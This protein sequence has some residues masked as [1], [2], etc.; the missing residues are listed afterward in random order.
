M[1]KDE[2]K[3]FSLVISPSEK[4][5]NHIS[6]DPMKLKAYTAHVMQEYA[7]N[8]RM[9][10]GQPLGEKDL[11]WVA[12]KHEERKHRGH[13]GAPSGQLKEGLQTHIHVMVSAHNKQQ[14]ITLNPLG[15]AARFNR[16]GFYAKSNVA[17]EQ[18][19]G[20]LQQDRTQ[21]RDAANSWA[22][23]Q[24]Q[25]QQTRRRTTQTAEEIADSIRRRAAVKDG[26]A[27]RPKRAYVNCRFYEPADE[28]RDR[29][30]FAQVDRA[31]KARSVDQQLEHNKVLEAARRLDYSKAFYGRLG[32]LEREAKQQ[33]YHDLPYKFLRTGKDP[34]MA[35]HTIAA[36]MKQDKRLLEQVERL[37][38]KLPKNGKLDPSIVLQVA[39]EEDYSKAFYRRLG[40]IGRQANTAKVVREPYEFLRTGRIQRIENTLPPD[41]L[42]RTNTTNNRTGQSGQLSPAYNRAGSRTARKHTPSVSRNTAGL[43]RDLGWA[44]ETEG[45]T[46]N[47]RGDEERD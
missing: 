32:Q 5:L 29:Q 36:Q 8:F 27:Q 24:A 6:N 9:K 16:V 23:K 40:R 44:M 42:D 10:S 22:D 4:E 34:K 13:D 1:R 17:F 33:H 26:R 39:R 25:S 43:G 14:K 38:T 20:P 28:K 35:A 19:F 18:V 21:R 47:I 45:Y 12:T 37:N 3:F 30:L 46:Q 41:Q 2:A 31:N 15:Q 11:V 7:A